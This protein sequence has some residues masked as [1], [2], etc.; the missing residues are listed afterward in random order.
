M[1]EVSLCHRHS[2]FIPVNVAV[3]RAFAGTFLD[4]YVYGSYKQLV[5]LCAQIRVVAGH[6]ITSSA[7]ARM[8]SGTVRRSAFAVFK[9]MTR[10]KRDGCITGKLAVGSPFRM[11]PA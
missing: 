11:R 9:L 8:V 10:S 1:F 3:H 7:N 2:P 6:S 5:S 4:R